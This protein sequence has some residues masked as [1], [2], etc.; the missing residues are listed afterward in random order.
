MCI[1]ICMFSQ[2]KKPLDGWRC[3]STV[4]PLSSALVC[5]MCSLHLSS[6]AG[7]EKDGSKHK[8]QG[9][10]EQMGKGVGAKPSVYVSYHWSFAT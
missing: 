2:K 7:M 6:S 9:E 3:S 5:Y 10:T 4:K 1:F 8:E